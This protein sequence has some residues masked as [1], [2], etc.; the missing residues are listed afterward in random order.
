MRKNDLWVYIVI[1]TI[2]SLVFIFGYKISL[3]RDLSIFKSDRAEF[4]FIKNESKYTAMFLSADGGLKYRSGVV[5]IPFNDEIKTYLA[6]MIITE[7]EKNKLVSF[8]DTEP[9]G[10]S[11]LEKFTLEIKKQST[12]VFQNKKNNI[13]MCVSEYPVGYFVINFIDAREGNKIIDV[14]YSGVDDFEKPTYG[15]GDFVPQEFQVIGNSVVFPPGVGYPVTY[16]RKGGELS[17]SE[18]GKL[19]SLFSL[20]QTYP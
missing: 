17:K 6:G 7:S 14:I 19:R 1:G 12:Y 20:E 9:V 4:W 8:Y 13:E 10:M 15:I 11:L 3:V 18:L 5:K 2:M 16:Y